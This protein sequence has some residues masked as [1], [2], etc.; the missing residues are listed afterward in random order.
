MQGDPFRDLGAGAQRE[1]SIS[2][3]VAL[4]AWPYSQCGQDAKVDELLNGKRDGV[5]VDVGAHDGVSFSNTFFFEIHRGWT[6]VCFEPNP[7]VFERLVINRRCVCE[8]VGVSTAPGTLRYLSITGGCEML[9]GFLNSYAPE[10]LKRI[11][12]EFKACGGTRREIDVPVV[13]LTQ[14]LEEKGITR[15]D[16]LSIDTEGGE[17]Q[18][19][20]ALDF[21]RIDIRIIGVENNYDDRRLRGVMAS[22]GFALHATMECDEIYV[23]TL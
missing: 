2:S 14:Y 22:N 6:G 20:E 23:K 10:H 11:E 1:F 4:F 16:Y 8:N 18:L 19:L 7:S 15:V 5:F 21:A 13:G 17:L 12:R 3:D 9:S